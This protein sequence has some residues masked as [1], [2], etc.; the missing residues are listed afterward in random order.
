MLR[1]LL[2]QMHLVTVLAS[3][4]GASHFRTS[5]PVPPYQSGLYLGAL[6]HLSPEHHSD[7]AER[8]SRRA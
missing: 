7:F 1:L 4:P 8:E 2:L 5:V 3:F 6:T